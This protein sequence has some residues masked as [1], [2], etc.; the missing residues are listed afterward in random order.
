CLYYL[1][2][3]LC[4]WADVVV[5]DYNYYFDMG[6]LLYSLTTL[7]EWRVAVLVDEAHN[8]VDRARSMYS[9]ELDQAIFHELLRRAPARIRSEL[10]RVGR[11]WEQLNRAQE[12]DYQIYP[13]VPDLFVA[14]LQ[15]AVTAITDHL[16]AQPGGNDRRLLQFYLDATPFRR[17]TEASG[18]H[19]PCDPT[20]TTRSALT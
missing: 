19:S 11:H 10:Q 12:H 2:Q 14:A 13:S 9:A 20:R 6:A 17:P 8:L 18:P 3:E 4:R 5:G 7:N 16:S 1:S 15:K